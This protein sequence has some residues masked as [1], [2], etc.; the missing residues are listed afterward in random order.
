M[1][2]FRLLRKIDFKLFYD[3]NE[4]SLLDNWNWWVQIKLSFCERFI[5]YY[6]SGKISSQFAER[7]CKILI[8]M[9]MIRIKFLRWT[10]MILKADYKTLS[11]LHHYR[12]EHASESAS[13]NDFWVPNKDPNTKMSLKIVKIAEYTAITNCSRDCIEHIQLLH[14]FINMIPRLD[15]KIILR[16]F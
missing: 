7:K 10:R 3:L 2:I 6:G 8:L 9:H 14:L 5:C 15:L 11:F 12:L 1:I 13:R 16:T 4:S